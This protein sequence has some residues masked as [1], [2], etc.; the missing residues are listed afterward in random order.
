MD[1]AESDLSRLAISRVSSGT[2]TGADRA[3]GRSDAGT[4]RGGP[5]N[6]PRPLVHRPACRAG[7]G[8]VWL[9]EQQ[10]AVSIE[11]RGWLIETSA[12]VLILSVLVAAA[13]VILLWRIL[14]SVL[15]TPHAIGRFRHHRRRNRSYVALVKSLAAL[16]SG[17]GV[18]ALRHASEAEAIGEPALGHLAAAEAAEMAGDTARAEE[19]YTRLADRPDTMMIGL[20]GLTGLAERQGNLD[21]ALAHVRRARKA[22]P[23]S[24]WAAGKQFELEDRAGALDQAERTL[25]D[26]AK[27][28]AISADRGRPAAGGAPAA[29]GRLAAEAKGNEADALADAERAHEL[30]PGLTKAAILAARLSAHAGRTPAA[31]RILTR[32]WTAAPDVELARAWLALAPKADTTARLRQAERLL[33]LDRSSDE[34]HLALAEAE[35]AGARWAEAR[36][37]L[38]ALSLSAQASPRFCHL[39]AYLESASGNET[40]ARGWFEKTLA[41]DG[42]PEPAATVAG[43]LKL[44]RRRP[45]DEA[46]RD[47]GQEATDMRQ[48]ADRC[49]LGRAHAQNSG[50]RHHRD[51]QPGH[52]HQPQGFFAHPVEP[53]DHDQR[54]EHA[55]DAGRGAD[56]QIVAGS[57]SANAAST[58]RPGD[59]RRL[60]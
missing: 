6:D 5:P 39:M 21:Q 19:E 24:P 56:H 32:A 47:A 34:G 30:E 31:E 42:P 29:T 15:G 51:Q 18:V 37:H 38:S 43:G 16:A 23:K 41:V 9:A 50:D 1:G 7:S 14:R 58:Q 22:S 48:P 57:G 33:A 10:G 44:R 55:A 40:A 35:L 28:G 11:W 20:R 26:A 3:G 52:A 36:S 60:K 49:A 54:A 12:G 27:L 46:H 25:A 8:A 13:L 59:A 45:D 4:Q 53:P 17:E 2:P